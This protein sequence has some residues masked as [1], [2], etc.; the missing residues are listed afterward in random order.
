M[1]IRK[2]TWTWN[3]KERCAWQLDWREGG[4]RR[5]KQF[6]TR[7]EAEFFR[8]KLIA[9]RHRTTYGP[10]VDAGTTFEAFLAVYT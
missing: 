9:E 1:N 2:R 6:R 3:G 7:Q 10:L 5:Q 8:D 4:V